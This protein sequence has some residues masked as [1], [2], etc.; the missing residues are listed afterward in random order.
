MGQRRGQRQRERQRRNGY[1][2]MVRRSGRHGDLDER[3][4][5]RLM[6]SGT[7]RHLHECDGGM[8]TF[9]GRISQATSSTTFR[10]PLGA[11]PKRS[12]WL[13]GADLGRD[14][15]DLGR[16]FDDGL[17]YGQSRSDRRRTQF[18]NGGILTANASRSRY[19]RGDDRGNQRNN[20]A[21]NWLVH[22]YRNWDT[23]GA[24]SCSRKARAR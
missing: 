8:M 10:S 11:S 17:A 2:V 3:F 4:D 20:H 5:V 22:E 21:H 12:R 24:G 7:G 15:H 19:R 1:V 6:D 23:S 13:R 14:A 9:A 18:G 16:L